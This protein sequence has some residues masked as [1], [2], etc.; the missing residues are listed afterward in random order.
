MRL[1]WF[2]Y[3]Y[4]S[5]GNRKRKVINNRTEKGVDF[6]ENKWLNAGKNSI[7]DGYVKTDDIFKDMCGIIESSQKAAYQAVNT[8]LVR[9]N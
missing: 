2:Y 5:V 9:R 7:K 3:I 8:T 1:W 6:L 4:R